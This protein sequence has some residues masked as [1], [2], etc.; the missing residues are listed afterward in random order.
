MTCMRV[1]VYLLA[2]PA[3]GLLVGLLVAV[4]TAE[5]ARRHWGVGCIYRIN[6]LYVLLLPP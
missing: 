3:V 6:R 5:R 2:L 4:L 1:G